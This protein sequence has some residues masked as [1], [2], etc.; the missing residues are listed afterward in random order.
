VL[1]PSYDDFGVYGIEDDLTQPAL[2][3]CVGRG[4]A[5]SRAGLRDIQGRVPAISRRAHCASSP[6]SH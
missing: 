1:S 2:Q 3:R 5:R 4:S 6:G